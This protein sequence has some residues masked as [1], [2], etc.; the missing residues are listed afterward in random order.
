MIEYELYWSYFNKYD[1]REY[2]E[3]LYEICEDCYEGYV[4]ICFYG[5]ENYLIF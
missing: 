5:S 2:L 4:S 3:S 1:M